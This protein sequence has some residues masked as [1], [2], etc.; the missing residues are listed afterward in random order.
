MACIQKYI[1]HHKH[2]K[3]MGVCMVCPSSSVATS[4]GHPAHIWAHRLNH[5]ICILIQDRVSELDS[6]VLLAH[7]RAHTCIYNIMME[8]MVTKPCAQ[9]RMW[10]FVDLLLRVN[11]TL[12]PERKIT[13]V[14]LLSIGGGVLSSLSRTAAQRCSL[15][16]TQVIYWCAVTQSDNKR[17]RSTNWFQFA[18]I[19]ITCWITCMSKWEERA[20]LWIAL[21]LRVDKTVN[22]QSM[23]F[24]EAVKKSLFWSSAH[25]LPSSQCWAVCIQSPRCFRT[26]SSWSCRTW[27]FSQVTSPLSA[28]LVYCSSLLSFFSV[29][30]NFIR[31]SQFECSQLRQ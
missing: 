11:V 17:E 19:N 3:R 25:C 10:R 18:I 12:K 14:I 28:P 7:A 4:S 24:G 8:K 9:Q 20:H 6:T 1:G 21:L 26:T 15:Y 13:V 29:Q 2:N 22:T 27:C 5:L 31:P 23:E 30:I 16:R